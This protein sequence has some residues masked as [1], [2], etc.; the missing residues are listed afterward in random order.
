VLPTGLYPKPI[1]NLNTISYY[2]FG[3]NSSYNSGTFSLRKRFARGL[4]FRV[5]YVFAKSIDTASGLNYAGDGGYAGAQDARNLNAERGRSDFDIRHVFSMNF[6]YQ[7]PSGHH[8]L[9]SGWQ[10][11]GTGRAYS[12]QPFTPQTSA[13]NT[14]LGE[15]TRPDRIATGTVA[16]PSPDRWFDVNAFPPV[17]LTAFRFG[18][19]GRNIL[20]GP[21]FMAINLSA[22]KRFRISERAE[23][24]LRWEAFNVTNHTDFKLPNVNVD[25]ANAGTIIAANPA[26]VMQLGLRLQF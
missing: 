9:T 11:A 24:Q 23:A 3:G 7:L 2:S 19:S 15:P 21:G 17:P 6:T 8:W 20:D 4:F 1:P 16:N 13:G 22:S 5:N 25:V 26:R 18:N 12:G 14:D 10:L